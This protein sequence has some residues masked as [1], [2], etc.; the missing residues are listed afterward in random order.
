[1]MNLGL[2]LSDLH[3]QAM[4]D[5]SNHRTASA[6]HFAGHYRLIDFVLSNMVNS[7]IYTVAIV[8]GS[9]YQTLLTH[10]GAGREWDL[11]R[12][13]GGVQYFPQYPGGE[14]R[15]ND[16]RD[17]PL[18]RA[19]GYIEEAKTD[20][21]VVV[22]GSFVY[23]IDFRE[24]LV[25]HEATG[26]DVT[27]IYARKPLAEIAQAHAVAFKLE[28]NGRVS[29]VI[30]MPPAQEEVNLFLGAYVIKKTALLRLLSR[31][32]FCDITKFSCELLG[33]A[34][35]SLKVLSWEY[36]GYAARISSLQTFF[37]YN[38]EML[39]PE[40]REP[41]FDSGGRRI[42]TKVHDSEP[43]KYGKDADV[44]NSII[45]NGCVIEG[46]VENCVLFRDVQVKAG[47]VVRNSVL[48]RNTVVS[49]N[50]ELN[51]IVTDKM[52]IISENRNLLGYKTH[53]VY[54]EKGKIV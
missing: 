50:A 2:C 35:K 39:D 37:H 8:L 1:M 15:Y 11:S 32:R 23:N 27:A 29:E 47:A 13:S 52:V 42:H 48:Q 4:G 14:R 24:P 34:L 20:Y 16:V 28:R 43:T 6:T 53:P 31:E 38:M 54:I 51:W 17:E 12:S 41:L 19:V 26:A 30:H 22:D 7:G 36:K 40:N 3:P 46:T 5:G 45:S 21:V 44:R 49:E 33:G 18:Q 25:Q 9:Q 10:I